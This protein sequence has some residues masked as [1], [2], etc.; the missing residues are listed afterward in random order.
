MLARDVTFNA[1]VGD[2]LTRGAETAAGLAVVGVAA[3]LSA[4]AVLGAAPAVA[5]ADA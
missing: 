1:S 5:G 3:A 2:L 4:A